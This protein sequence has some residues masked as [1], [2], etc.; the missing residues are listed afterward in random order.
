MAPISLFYT[1]WLAAAEASKF[2]SLLNMNSPNENA[3]ETA[4]VTAI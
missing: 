1:D 3:N 4:K 2:R